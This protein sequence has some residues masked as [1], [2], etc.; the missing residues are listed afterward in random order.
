MPTAGAVTFA[1]AAVHRCIMEGIGTRCPLNAGTI[2]IDL[3]SAHR[4]S[5]EHLCRTYGIRRLDLFG[6]AATGTFDP[7][8]SDIDFIVDLG[9]YEPGVT[10]RF[11]RFA[12]ALEA[13]LGRKVDLITDE[14]IQNPYFRFSVD[15]SRE[16]VYEA[17][18]RQA[19]A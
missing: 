19:A 11:L 9:G 3:I 7:A 14:Q 13:L 2:M 18:D 8:T 1:K 10:R 12:D 4:Q 6:S 15:Q 17:V 16:R 5:I